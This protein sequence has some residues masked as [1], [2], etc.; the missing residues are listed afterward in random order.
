[1]NH[2][3][4]AVALLVDADNATL[5]SLDAV[6]SELE[7]YGPVTIRRAYGNWFKSG[8]KS[9][10]SA[11][12]SRGIRA[13]Q[14]SDPVKGKNATDLALAIDAVDIHHTLAP[15]VFGLVSSDSD[16]STLALYLRE[17][18]ATVVGFGRAATPVSFQ[19]ACTRFV[20]IVAPSASKP[21]PEPAPTLTLAEQ[22]GASIAKNAD[23]QGWARVS[24]VA[25]SMRQDFGQSAKDHG[26]ASW[27]KVMRSLPG[28]EFRNDGTTNVAVRVTKTS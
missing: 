27:T 9:W 1:M 2:S 22:L 20:E 23:K 14:Q 24:V 6:L 26:K 18:G 21:S 19:A 5:A 13:I 17:Q 11:L 12:T 28:F 10:D 25:N 3:T 4:S 15:A 8:L 7:T 16:F